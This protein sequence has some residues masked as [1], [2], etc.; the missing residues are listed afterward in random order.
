MMLFDI[1]FTRTMRAGRSRPCPWR[2]I[3]Q[4]R[5][6]RLDALLTEMSA[7]KRLKK[8]SPV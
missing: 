5:L 8:R 3:W 1:L 4:Q 2:L 6:D 7:T